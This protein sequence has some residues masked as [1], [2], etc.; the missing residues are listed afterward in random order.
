M[1][2]RKD[3]VHFMD[4]SCRFL[5]FSGRIRCRSDCFPVGGNVW[6]IPFPVRWLPDRNTASLIRVF[7]GGFRSFSGMETAGM[8][9]KV[10]GFQPVP[11][12]IRRS[13]AST[14]VPT[15]KFLNRDQDLVKTKSLDSVSLDS[16]GRNHF[17]TSII[18]RN[19]QHHGI[20]SFLL[21]NSTILSS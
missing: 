4:S 15:K 17:R 18:A 10:H 7:S 1:W 13:E 14:W 11:D 12:R 6:N 5:I 21:E 8:L 3:P 2:F 20:S 16:S 9:R 19:Q